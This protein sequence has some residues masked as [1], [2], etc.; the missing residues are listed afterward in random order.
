MLSICDIR[1]RGE[2]ARV[3]D[4]SHGPLS[5]PLCGCASEVAAGSSHCSVMLRR[6]A[7]SRCSSKCFGSCTSE[8]LC[9][10]YDAAAAAAAGGP[11]EMGSK[12][13]D[14]AQLKAH[15]RGRGCVEDPLA[16]KS[17]PLQSLPSRG[18][19][20]C[21][22][23]EALLPAPRGGG[24]GAPRAAASPRSTTRAAGAPPVPRSWH[25]HERCPPAVAHE[26]TSRGR[27]HRPPAAAAP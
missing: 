14:A 16:M 20:P 12:A 9:S 15:L 3:R 13:A 5:L 19:L 1:A 7:S 4:G 24:E 23:A 8:W 11:C 27:W 10:A 26:H 17:P 22:P 6:E 25:W 21:Q 2:R 18:A